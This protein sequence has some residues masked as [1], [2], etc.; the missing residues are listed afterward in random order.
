MRHVINIGMLQPILVNTLQ[1]NTRSRRHG[2][3]VA[4]RVRSSGRE[5]SGRRARQRQCTSYTSTQE[6]ATHNT[7]CQRRNANL[8]DH[9]HTNVDHNNTI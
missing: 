1:D 5:C 2:R 4:A 3:L 7:D 8:E 6:Y 9:H